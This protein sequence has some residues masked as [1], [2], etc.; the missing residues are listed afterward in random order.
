M[1]LFKKQPEQP[2]E[3][4]V[5]LDEDVFREERHVGVVVENLKAFSDAEKIQDMI[6]EG[7][8][9][10]LR[11][12]EMRET[13]INE[14]KRAVEK[15]KKTVYASNGDI[16]GVEEDMLIICPPSAKIFRG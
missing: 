16:V 9:V 4:R 6:R 15:L 7:K 12:R 14:L 1:A 8:V 3:D 11:I 10:F 13:D 5:E 2:M